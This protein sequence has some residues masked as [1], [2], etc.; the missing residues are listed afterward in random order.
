MWLV[1][2]WLQF[3]TR[4]SWQKSMLRIII[5]VFINEKRKK[6]P[7][8]L[9]NGSIK[10]Q[11]SWLQAV[12]QTKHKFRKRVLKT[13]SYLTQFTISTGKVSLHHLGTTNIEIKHFCQVS[14]RLK[15]WR[16]PEKR[17]SESLLLWGI[18][19]GRKISY[20]A[21]VFDE[22]EPSWLFL[23]FPE[24]VLKF[25]LKKSDIRKLWRFMYKLDNTKTI[26]YEFSWEL[27]I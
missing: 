8:H 13:F 26:L 17:A 6:N 9:P 18:H 22:W 19:A 3:F 20:F 1:I 14:E 4:W 23:L 24:S 10:Q 15:F 16:W 12:Q 11:L 27:N 21:G 2:M 25:S 7:L 5:I